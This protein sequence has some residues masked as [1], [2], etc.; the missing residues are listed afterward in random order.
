MKLAQGVYLFFNESLKN[1][2]AC[3]KCKKDLS[4][5]EGKPAPIIFSRKTKPYC[6]ACVYRLH[7]TN[8]IGTV[9]NRLGTGNRGH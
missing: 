6:I 8:Y 9:K 5:K 4:F 3:T 1:Q 2:L 7:F